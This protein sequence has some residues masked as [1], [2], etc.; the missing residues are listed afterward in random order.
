MP[1]LDKPA[2]QWRGTA[3]DAAELARAY[4]ALASALGRPELRRHVLRLMAA[5]MALG[6][7][8]G[9]DPSTPDG[10]YVPAVTQAPDIVPGVPNQYATALLDGGA[11]AGIVVT[12]AM[13][14]P[15]KV[16]GNPAHPASLGATSIHGQALILD[17]Y[18]PDRSCGLMQGGQV[19]A[20]QSLERSL[21]AQRAQLAA[22]RGAGFRILTGEVISPTLGAAIDRLLQR[23]PDARWHQWE[24]AAR[25]AV[26]QGTVLAYGR[27][28]DLLPRVAAAD[29]IVA[30]DGDLISGSPGYLRH[31]RDFASR[32]NPVRAPM[33]R[34]YAAEPVP[35]M[36]GMAADHRF[37][38]GP[39]ALHATI[40]GLAA[41]VLEGAPPADAPPWVAPMAADLTQAGPHAL[42]HAG[43][44]VPAPSQALVHAINER[45]G[46]R[47][48]TFDLIEPVA[49]RTGDVSTG[50]AT[51]LADM[52]AGRVETLLIL[53]SNPVYTVPGFRAAM[54]RVGFSLASAASPDETARAATWHVPLAHLFEAWG[55]ARAHD[56]T[57][58]I[59]QPQAL[60]L[61]GGRSAFEVLALFADGTPVS[62]RDVVR[63]A[64][65]QLDDAAWR[66]ALAS[67]VILGTASA[68]AQDKLSM[69]PAAVWQPRRRRRVR[70]RCL[71]VR[72]PISATAVTPTI[73]GCRNCRGPSANWSGAIR[74]WWRPRPPRGRASRT[75]TRWCC[76]SAQAP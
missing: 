29:V 26:R 46:A 51:L 24:P 18:D 39:G 54:A 48:T 44:D 8:G 14:R 9:C 21:L 61:Y 10:T 19:A 22:S 37:I 16:E 23:Y 49:H 3:D 63:Q 4:P 72:T 5:S 71:R 42:V 56:G 67:G 65:P 32:R 31:V 74:C 58:S 1:P 76:R 27:P 36:I 41:A 70:S 73:R 50:I 55:D 69:Q 12:Q 43:P 53:D 25:D 15:I 60:P 52:Q 45:L 38:A 20:W 30:L 40:T 28:L 68:P 66:E 17:F 34:V 47:G 59:Q 7:L 33:S 64:W 2:R 62:G 11:A 13:G 75:A 35:T 57:I 6:G